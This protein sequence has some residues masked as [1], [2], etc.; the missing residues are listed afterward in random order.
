MKP[1]FAL[2]KKLGVLSLKKKMAKM[3]ANNSVFYQPKKDGSILC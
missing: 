1:S 2:C 3:P